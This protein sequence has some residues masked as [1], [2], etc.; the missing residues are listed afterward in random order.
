M[1]KIYNELLI[2]TETGTNIFSS[3]T[4]GAKQ[5]GVEMVSGFLSALNTFAKSERGENMKELTLEQTTFIFEKRAGLIYII[6]TSEPKAKPLL[7]SFLDDLIMAF[8]NRFKKEITSFVGNV[9]PFE[10]FNE[11]VAAERLDHAID[12]I[13]EKDDGFDENDVLQAIMAISRLTGEI[14]FTRAKQYMNKEDLEF[15]V[16]LIVKAGERTGSQLPDQHTGWILA[17]SNKDKAMLIQPRAHV[18]LVEEYRLPFELPDSI[19]KVKDIRERFSSASF[20]PEIKHVK[21]IANSGK[22]LD[23]RTRDPEYAIKV[24]IDATMLVTAG[25]NLVGKYYKGSLKAIAT[26]DNNKAM[27]FVPFKDFFV[28]A[29]GPQSEFRKFTAIL[30]YTRKLGG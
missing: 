22:V 28:V 23:E 19:S 16:P 30:E 21:L 1:T 6:T 27:L 5:E 26:G 15:L 29:R 4:T 13:D 18:I 20:L 24:D 2:I 12:S 3:V 25:S 11:H 8:E 9:A 14:L 7:K 17:V 10:A